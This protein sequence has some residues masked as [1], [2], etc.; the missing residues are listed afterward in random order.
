M[1]NFVLFIAVLVGV[2]FLSGCIYTD[3]QRQSAYQAGMTALG[4]L[5]GQAIGRDTKSTLIGAGA[6]YIAGGLTKEWA[7]PRQEETVVVQEQH[8]YHQPARRVHNSGPVWCPPKPLCVGLRYAESPYE[9]AR[10]QQKCRVKMR[11]YNQ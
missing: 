1:R 2:M 8:Y 5:G 6:G 9:R 4:A 7:Y 3:G 11:D 10:Q